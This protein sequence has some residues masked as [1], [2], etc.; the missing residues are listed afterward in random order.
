MSGD[1]PFCGRNDTLFESDLCY[2][3]HDMFPVSRGHTLVIPRR[4]YADLFESTK[5][6]LEAF[7]DMIGRVRSFLDAAYA[8]GGYNIGVNCGRAAGQSIMHV[9]IHVIPRYRDDRVD[10]TGG[11]RGVIPDRRRYP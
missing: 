2:A 8:P 4:H 10:P 11:V 5:A 1:C 6:E 7:A 3:I 9:H